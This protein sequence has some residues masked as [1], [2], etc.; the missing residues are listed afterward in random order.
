MILYKYMSESGAQAILAK[1]SVG[2]AKPG[3]FNDPYELEAAYPPEGDNPLSHFLS[4]ARGIGKRSRWS[5]TSG[6]LCL[7]RNPLSSLMWAHYANEHR[8]VVLGFDVEKAGFLDT[9]RCLI[10]AQFGNIVYTDTRPT[11]PMVTLE[12]VEPIRMGHTHHYPAGHEEK[13]QRIFL[14]KPAC[15]SY[16]EEVRVVKCLSDRIDG[17]N[18]SGTFTELPIAKKTLYC[19]QLPAG[20]IIEAYW[21]MRHPALASIESMETALKQ[22]IKLCPNI[23][24]RVCTLSDDTWEIKAVGISDDVS[25]GSGK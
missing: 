24:V 11:H 17:T 5:D 18:P 14:Q 13:I 21:G 1:N 12:G 6:V 20:T 16:E 25:R 7:T 22:Y 23:R 10:P 4:S 3:T 19:Y 2:F 9:Q 15:W 8:G